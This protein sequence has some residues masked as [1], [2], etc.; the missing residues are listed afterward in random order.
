DGTFMVITSSRDEM[1]EWVRDVASARRQQSAQGTTE[2]GTTE[3][4]TTEQVLEDNGVFVG[5]H[6][7][8]QKIYDEIMEGKSSYPAHHQAE[9]LLEAGRIG[10]WKTLNSHPHHRVDTKEIDI[11]AW[12][13]SW[14]TVSPY[15]RFV[16]LCERLAKE[17]P[18]AIGRVEGVNFNELPKNELMRLYINC[19]T[20]LNDYEEH[21]ESHDAE[22]NQLFKRIKDL[23]QETHE[24]RINRDRFSEMKLQFMV[25]KH[26]NLE[27][28]AGYFCDFVKK[29]ATMKWG[30]AG[31]EARLRELDEEEE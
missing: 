1:R 24:M 25:D 19:K 5:P 7:S 9:I 8:F 30:L 11:E 14:G 23:A 29:V 26:E 17:E 3:Q 18:D 31:S 28:V 27:I 10:V 12:K 2:Q 15:L 20:W 13:K 4:G 22:K 16:E 21:S 6:Q